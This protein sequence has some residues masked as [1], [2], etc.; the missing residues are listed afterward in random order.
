VV[1]F[2][3]GKIGS[4]KEETQKISRNL[5]GVEGGKKGG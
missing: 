5:L 2:Y 1:G 4:K 3:F